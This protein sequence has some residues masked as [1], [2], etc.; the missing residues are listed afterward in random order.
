MVFPRISIVLTLLSAGLLAGCD[1]L[2][3]RLN[4]KFPPVSADDH[5]TS[6][7]ETSLS[8]LNGAKTSNL[9]VNLRT[10][11]FATVLSASELKTKFGISSVSIGGDRQLLFAT[12]AVDKR[13]SGQ[14][15]SVPYHQT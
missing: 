6:A 5:R 3:T 14:D 2:E 15:F 1:S 10:S 4:Q 7:V 11:D 8:A 13:F 9:A 12:I